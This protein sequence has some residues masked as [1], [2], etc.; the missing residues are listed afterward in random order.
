MS[1]LTID[2]VT[3]CISDRT[4]PVAFHLCE[5]LLPVEGRGAVF[6][7]PTY[8]GG[9]YAIDTLADG[10][11]TVTVDSVGS[12]ANRM[13]PVFLE[14]ELRHLVPQVTVTYR[15][16]DKSEG[17]ISLL[18]AGHRLGDALVRATALFQDAHDAFVALE[19]T[20]NASAIAR[21]APTSIV[22]GAW[23]SRDTQ[24]KLPRLVQSV[25]RAWDVSKLSRSAQY[26]PALDYAE[27]EVFS[28]KDKEKA[29]GSTKSPLAKRGFVH[30][31][32]TDAHGGV[33]ARGPIR[34]D[35]TI[36]LVALRRIEAG[37]A[38]DTL[39]LR[40]YILGLCLVAAIEPQ[41]PFFRQ[42]CLLVPDPQTP[43]KWSVVNRSGERSE[44]DLTLSEVR[45]R[46]TEW[47]ESFGVGP[48]R[49][50]AFDKKAAVADAKKK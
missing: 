23:D 43:P 11:K 3:R 35:L 6:F 9:G 29:E 39:A 1:L 14:P 4:G 31:P 30:V 48:D 44:A 19:R 42:G 49:T 46:A 27:L 38:E 28:E 10:T 20:G 8:A 33:V 13:E 7:P 16:K 2:F 41:D 24:A 18:E 21:L 26:E 22:F 45:G 40:R 5:H 12:Q 34:R 50:V 32:A 36:N 37:S 15:R 25:V 17:E 47:A